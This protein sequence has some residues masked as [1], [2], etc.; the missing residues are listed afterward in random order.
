MSM[1]LLERKHGNKYYKLLNILTD[2]NFLIKA[3]NSIKSKPGNITR[4][5]DYETLD[6]ISLEYFQKVSNDIKQNKF[7]FKPG[8]VVKIPKKDPNKYRQLTIIS[9][10][11]KIV[12]KAI[13]MILQSIWEP[14]FSDKSHGFRPNR[15][16]H[17]ALANIYLTGNRFSWVIQGDLI[18]CFDNIPHEIIMR[19]I[20][21]RIGDPALIALLWKFLRAGYTIDKKYV[22]GTIGVPQGSILSPFLANVVLD[23]FDKYMEKYIKNFN[24][25]KTR[26]VS[27]EYNKLIYYLRRAKDQ[28]DFKEIKRINQLIKT[29][30]SV[31]YMDTK[32]KRLNY[33]RYADDFVILV[34]GSLNDAKHIKLNAK[35][36]LRSHCEAE[37]N[38]EKTLITNIM[39]NKFEFLGADIRKPRRTNI[40]TIR[41][42]V[43]LRIVPRIFVNAPIYKLIQK[44]I[45]TGFI[46]RDKAGK[47]WPL[48]YNKI[49]NLSHYEIIKFYNS[50]IN[51]IVNY[52][53]F[54]SNRPKLQRIL[55]YLQFSCAY[56]LATKY[57]STMPK[58]FQKFGNSLK[59]KETDIKLNLYNSL[60]VTH[61]FN[62][63]L[64]SDPFQNMNIS[65]SNK[66]T[67]KTFGQTCK[68]CGTTTQLEAHHL[69]K[70]ADIRHLMRTSNSTYAKW[71]GATNRKQIIICKYHHQLLHKGQL[72]PADLKKLYS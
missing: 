62:K 30:A 21:K 57:K 31:D 70:V 65:W 20:Q 32:F 71:I 35:E 67:Q 49:V 56:T 19:E 25:G 47:I 23:L 51:G 66:I 38:D 29:M 39:D 64:I 14:I 37:L 55:Y 16:T 44:L 53:S 68:I 58:M 22:K 6:G 40:T 33:I 7:K 10:R 12:Q 15:S 52:Y 41:N 63:T 18:K 54:A 50:K 5:N 42:G 46:R 48:S 8:R 45:D 9:P 34:S 3:Y 60:K 24:I 11:D 27:R 72:T 2:V 61:Y 28:N 13:L 17:T 1:M 59:D 43:D 69:R 4:G 36:F 26:K